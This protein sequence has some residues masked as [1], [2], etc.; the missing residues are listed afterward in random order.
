[1]FEKV[2]LSDEPSVNAG[3]YM[4]R[5]AKRVPHAQDI[6]IKTFHYLIKSSGVG[7]NGGY[8]VSV[9]W[10]KSQSDKVYFGRSYS[11]FC[12]SKDITLID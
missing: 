4:L 5:K 3:K 6:F 2:V 9:R 10:F 7:K 12:V 8:Q 1:M 11:E